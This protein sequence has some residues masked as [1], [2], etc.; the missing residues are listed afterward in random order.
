MLCYMIRKWE[1]FFPRLLSKLARG[2]YPEEYVVSKTQESHQVVC[3]FF[4]CRR[5]QTQ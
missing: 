2:A 4:G 1:N 3:L 5:A